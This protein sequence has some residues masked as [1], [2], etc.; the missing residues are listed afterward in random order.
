MSTFSENVKEELC[1]NEYDLTSSKLIVFA[2][3]ANKL[4][5]ILTNNKQE[6]YLESNFNFIIRFIGQCLKEVFKIDGHYSY[7]DINS[8]SKRRTFRLTITDWRFVN[9]L[10]E[11]DFYQNSYLLKKANEK[12]KKAFLI[13]AFLANG[14]ISDPNKSVYHLEIRS[15]QNN[16]LR[17]LQTIMSEFNL[18]PTILQRKYISVIYIKKCIVI[19]DFLKIIGAHNNMMKLEDVVIGRDF[20]NQNNRLN[21]LDMANL[22]KTVESGFQQVKMIK[23]IRQANLL[24]LSKNNDKFKVFCELRTLYPSKSLNE[25]VKEFEQRKIKITRSGINHL[26]IKLRN[27]YNQIN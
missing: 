27:L 9:V 21:N 1:H 24:V 15:H 18:S 13:G 6:W 19:S 12:E 2:F 5:I 25:L 4:K 11:I 16:Y 3:I 10:E 22:N 23:K 8:F 7:S 14:S 26:V 17:L 20:T